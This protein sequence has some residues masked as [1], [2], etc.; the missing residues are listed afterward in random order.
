MH[1]NLVFNKTKIFFNFSEKA[2]DWFQELLDELQIWYASVNRYF[3]FDFPLIT[4]DDET[5]D[6]LLG[7]VS[8]FLGEKYTFR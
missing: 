1:R 2:P 5:K 6:K 8:R 4:S 3:A 7:A